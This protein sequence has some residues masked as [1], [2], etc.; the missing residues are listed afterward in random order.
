MIGIKL[1]GQDSF[2]ELFPDTSISIKLENPILGNAEKLSPGSF[3]LP[4]DIPGGDVNPKNSSLLKNPDVI[5]NNEAYQTQ[6]AS[7]FYNGQPLKKGNLKSNTFDTKRI[8]S[9]F[10]FGLNSLK[11]SFKT[12]KL[13]DIINETQTV[14]TDPVDKTIYLKKLGTSSVTIEIN[15]I[16]FTAPTT[17]DL[18]DVINAYY[19]DNMIVDSG[20]FLPT[21]QAKFSGSSPL[22]ITSIYLEINLATSQNVGGFVIEVF[23]TDPMEVLYVKIPEESQSDFLVETSSLDDYY[24]AFDTFVSAAH[25]GTQLVFPVR[26]NA[27]LH[28]NDTVKQYEVINGVTVSGIMRNDPNY[29]FLNGSTTP[30][31]NYNSLQPFLRLKW[32]LDK[33]AEEFEFEY[34]GDFYDDPVT[35]TRVIDNSQT[36]DVLQDLFG[37]TKFIKW[38]RSFNISE[39][40]PEISIVDFFKFLAGRYNLGIFPN[41]ATGKV[42][43]KYREEVALNKDYEDVTAIASTI[44]FIQDERITGFTIK[45]KKEDTDKFSID[46]T[47]TVGT[48]EK[49]LEIQAGRIHASQHMIAP[50]GGLIQGP[51]VSQKN[52]EKFS[53]RIFHY[54]G[55]VDNGT[56]SYHKASINGSGSETLPA[57]YDN[58]WKYWLMFEMNRVLIRL[59]LNIPFR[60]LIQIVWTLKRRYNRNNFIFKS[61]DLKLSNKGV[62]ASTTELYTMR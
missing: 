46:E 9:Y 61:I 36:L 47:M 16:S 37:F 57:L 14:S 49:T 19:A 7:L 59:K 53:L 25:A 44:E 38:R 27:N 60:K 22:G 11:N 54:D 24:D 21:S 30:I 23:S 48:S 52:G 58:Y 41:E 17:L 18:S 33:I 42:C 2:L 6:K 40:V 8:N 62:Q 34:E 51:Y 20:L 31:K 15:G 50:G 10:T 5:E 26:F 29:G 3:S 35:A 32:V 1:D 4:F 12:A 39:L 45:V 28:G 55:F 56:F 13:R 43:M